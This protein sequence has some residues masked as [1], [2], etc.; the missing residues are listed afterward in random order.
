MSRDKAQ[1]NA[2]GGVNVSQTKPNWGLN[3]LSSPVFSLGH[4]CWLKKRLC[5]AVSLNIMLFC[6][7]GNQETRLKVHKLAFAVIF[8][9]R[10]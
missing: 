5:Q 2:F 8:K 6:S 3:F 9:V 4:G 1:P 10:L 7:I